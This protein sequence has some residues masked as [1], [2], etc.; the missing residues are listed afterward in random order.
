MWP[1][2]WFGFLWLGGEVALVFALRIPSDTVCEVHGSNRDKAVINIISGGTFKV[3]DPNKG[4][5]LA[6]GILTG[7]AWRFLM[8]L[9]IGST[10]FQYLLPPGTTWFKI[11]EYC[12]S[13]NCFLAITPFSLSVNFLDKYGR[14]Q[15]SFKH[16]S[17]VLYIFILVVFQVLAV[18]NTPHLPPNP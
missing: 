9:D 12:N 6:H 2:G 13:L 5:W 10:L 15:F 17:M 18:F 11:H 3:S 14:K 7:L 8:L 1:R 4:K 16:A